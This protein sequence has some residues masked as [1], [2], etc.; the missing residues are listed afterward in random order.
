[1]TMMNGAQKENLAYFT[2]E[3][4][5]LESK[6]NGDNML[7]EESKV[8]KEMDKNLYHLESTSETCNLLSTWPLF[9]SFR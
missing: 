9:L 1:M 2:S 3:T 5:F 4:T 7:Q 6:I 8:H